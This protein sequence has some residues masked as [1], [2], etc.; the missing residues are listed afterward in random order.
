MHAFSVRNLSCPCTCCA[1]LALAAGCGAG[2]GTLQVVVEAEDTITHGLVPGEELENVVDGWTATFDKYIAVLGHVRLERT[3][4]DADP[5]EIERLTAVD[6]RRLPA[7]GF[8]LARFE[9]IREGRW[10]VFEY[11]TEHP[12]ASDERADNVSR[13]DFEALRDAEA[14]FLI[15][16]SLTKDDG[17][18]CPPGGECRS[19]TRIDYRLLVP[20]ETT[21]GPCEAED[22][23]PG[24]VVNDGGTT[25]V[26]IVIHG[27]HFFFNRFPVGAEVIE[28]RAQWLAN[29]DLDGDGEVTQGELEGISAAD[30]FPS[31]H[32][33]VAGAPIPIETG[34]D[35]VRA[36]LKT[37]GHFQG[38]GECPWDGSGRHDHAH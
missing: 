25:T 10:D 33:S 13:A 12:G 21:Y 34:W 32:Y 8:P 35:F 23:L 11:V 36:Q 24:A 3:D 14:S 31:Q 1:L 4:G 30:L 29:A 5:V 2:R 16:G 38:E 19:A 9:D 37:V 6:L 15:E 27:D 20:A 7:T 26:S 18:S 28:R 17:E 22:G